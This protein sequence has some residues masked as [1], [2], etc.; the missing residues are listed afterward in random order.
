MQRGEMRRGVLQRRARAD[1]QGV[2][3]LLDRVESGDAAEPDDL[4]QVAQLLGD[5]QADVGRAADQHGARKAGVKRGER[6]FARRR[7]EEGVVVA[8][9]QVAAVGERR[10]RRGALGGRGG[11]TIGRPAVAGRQRRVDD[12]PIA[13]ATAEVA[14]ERVARALVGRRLALVIER[15]QAHDDAGRAE[16]A[17]RAVIVDHRLLHRMQALALGEVLDGQHFG[18]VDLAEQQDAGVDRLVAQSAV[19]LQPRQDDGAGAAVALIAALLRPL[20]AGFLAQPIEQRRARREAIEGDGSA[21]KAEHQT[22]AES[23]SLY[24]SP[25]FLPRLRVPTS[26]PRLRGDGSFISRRSRPA[27]C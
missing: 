18:A 14:G 9:E 5:P 10:Q 20:G 1:A 16:A 27:R 4:L 25:P 21:A 6:S 12:R 2:P 13:G 22:A 23:R 17:L 15:E 24:R 8:D 19:G 7:G 11:E 26:W 3:A